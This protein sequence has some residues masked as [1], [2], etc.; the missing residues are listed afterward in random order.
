MR[1]D[2]VLNAGAC[3]TESRAKV[4]PGFCYGNEREREREGLR[5][6]LD[7]GAQKTRPRRFQRSNASVYLLYALCLLHGLFFGS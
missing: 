3:T 7:L 6:P 5:T 2:G 4:A 1:P